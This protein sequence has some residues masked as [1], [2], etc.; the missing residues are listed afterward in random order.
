MHGATIKIKII[1]LYSNFL[2]VKFYCM[3]CEENKK[4]SKKC[5]KN[6]NINLPGM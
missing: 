4:M 1:H 2:E 3:L 6:L 5:E